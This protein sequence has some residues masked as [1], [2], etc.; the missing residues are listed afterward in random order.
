M[1]LKQRD[2]Y[3]EKTKETA[4]LEFVEDLNEVEKI[5]SPRVLNTHL[6]YRWFPKAHTDNKGKIIHVTRNPKDVFVSYFY[7]SKNFG[8]D[9][10]W[11]TYYNETIIGP[12][13][14]KDLIAV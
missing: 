5:T 14:Y 7:F 13:K 3:I 12:G 2:E 10:D 6:P 1:L 9:V 8:K 11:N 4:F